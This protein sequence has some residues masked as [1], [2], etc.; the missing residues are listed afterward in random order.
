MGRFTGKLDRLTLTIERPQ[1]TPDDVKKLM[2]AQR[3]NKASE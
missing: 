2:E 1:L 3:N